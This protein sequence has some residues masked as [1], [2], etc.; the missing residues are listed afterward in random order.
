MDNRIKNLIRLCPLLVK[1]VQHSQQETT[2][3][4]NMDVMLQYKFQTHLAECLIAVFSSASTIRIHTEQLIIN[5]EI[6]YTP[7]GRI[8]MACVTLWFIKI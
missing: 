5:L 6:F 3:E 4:E 2:F 7:Y 1:I 8:P